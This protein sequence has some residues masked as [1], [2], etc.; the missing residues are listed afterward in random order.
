[1]EQCILNFPLNVDLYALNKP[2]N[3]FGSHF[4]LIEKN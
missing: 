4:P 2:F 3:Y 1:M